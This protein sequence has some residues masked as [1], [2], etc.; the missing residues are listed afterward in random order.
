ML[1]LLETASNQ[2]AKRQGTWFK[3]DKAIN[4]VKTTA[5]SF[6][7]VRKWLFDKR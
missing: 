6:Q 3:R 5:K 2:Y 4:W 7:I 1:A